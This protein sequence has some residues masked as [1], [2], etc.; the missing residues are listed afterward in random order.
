LKDGIVLDDATVDQIVAELD[1]AVPSGRGT[2]SFP[3]R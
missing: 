2:V 1:D 3:R